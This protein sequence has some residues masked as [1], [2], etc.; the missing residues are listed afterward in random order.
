M[1]V[2]EII[3]KADELYPNSRAEPDKIKE[4]DVLDKRLCRKFKV[5]TVQT[6]EILADTASYPTGIRVED[7]FSVTVNG[8]EY[9]IKQIT[10]SATGTSRYVTNLNGY[11]V[12]Y[13][14]PTKD[15]TMSVYYYGSAGDITTTIKEPT[16][17]ED[18][19]MI[20]V[21]SLCATAA[22]IAREDDWQR[23]F[24]DQYNALERE[25]SSVFTDPEVKTIVSESGW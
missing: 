19:H 16:L 18:Y 15:G 1:L 14:T 25:L 9:P 22:T 23:S 20:F 24:A 10:A 11:T 6:F 5:Q 7:M 21:Y 4:I 13:P 3:A 8:E 17:D 2:S 12:I